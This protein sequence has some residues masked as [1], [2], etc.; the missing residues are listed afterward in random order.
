M[1]GFGTVWKARDVKLDRIVAL[2]IP[3]R[4]GLTG[5]EKE[6]FLREARAAARF[7]RC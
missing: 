4:G 6:K 5:S 1:G 3:R 2:K 7:R